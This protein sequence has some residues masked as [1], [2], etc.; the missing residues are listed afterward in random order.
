MIR[1]AV[2]AFAKGR[3]RF[4]RSLST[5]IVNSPHEID[6]SGSQPAT[7]KFVMENFL[8]DDWRNLDAIVDG[9]TGKV[10]TYEQT[11]GMTYSLAQNLRKELNL[12]EGDVVAIMSP[13]NLNYFACFH[14]IALTGAASTTINP[15]YTPDESIGNVDTDTFLPKSTYNDQTLATIPFSSGT[16]GRAKG[17]MLTHANLT[18]NIKHRSGNRGVLLCPL[19]FF[20]IYGMVAGMCM[21]LQAGGKLVF[22]SAFDLPLFLSLIQEHKVTRGHVVPPIALALAKHPLVDDYKLDS[23]ETL[24]SGAAPLGGEIQELASLRLNCLVKQAW[25]MTELSPAGDITEANLAKIRGVSGLLVPGTEGKIVHPETGED[26]PSTEEGELLIRG[27]QVM[28]GYLNNA[29]ATANTIR[30]DGWMHTGDIGKFDEDGFLIITDRSKELIKY[31][32]FQVPP[33][34]LEALI[35]TMPEVKDCVVIPVLD[36][37]AGEIPRAYVVK[38]DGLVGSPE[39]DAFTEDQVIDYVASKVAPYKKLRGGVVFADSVPK[40][41]SG[42]LLRRIQVQIDRGEI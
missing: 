10:L 13:N 17:V 42:K 33:A 5:V 35:L 14:G 19:P 18:S 32:G 9:H 3:V 37:E 7:P 16:T 20:H 34:E 30:P 12:K 8:K 25:G 27:P 38:Q 2:N 39:G 29:E 36:D 24:M 1:L 21:P 31:K 28:K 22:M 26:I 11:Y 40:S 41:P 15:L 23:L 6:L 4:G